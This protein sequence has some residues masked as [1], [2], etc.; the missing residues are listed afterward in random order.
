MASFR[1]RLGKYQAQ[2]RLDGFTKTKTFTTLQL[3]K[4]WAAKQEYL[5]QQNSIVKRN[6]HPQNFEEILTRY[7]KEVTQRKAT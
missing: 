2:V 3:A 4:S 5:V 7:L 1:K 6:Y